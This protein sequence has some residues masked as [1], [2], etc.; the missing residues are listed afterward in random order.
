MIRPFSSCVKNSLACYGCRNR[1]A[2]S[3]CRVRLNGWLRYIE[4]VFF[5]FNLWELFR[6]RLL[7]SHRATSFERCALFDYQR[8]RLNVSGQLRRT[9]QLNALAGD[10][11]AV[12]NPMDRRDGHFD[13]RIDLAARAYDQCAAG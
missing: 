5:P 10:D 4:N 11:V 8:R 3:P 6:S 12:D 7:L 13:I 1:L 2:F 9:A